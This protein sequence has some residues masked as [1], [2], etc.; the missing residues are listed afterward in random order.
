MNDTVLVTGATGFVGSAVARRLLE[1][2]YRV[3]ALVRQSSA[4]DNLQGLDLE[5]VMGDL[6]DPASLDRALQGC[7]G[8]FH[9]AADYRLWARHP[10]ELYASNVQGTR[11]IML[12]AERAGVRRIVYTSSVATMGLRADGQSAD[13]ETPVTL[14]D[15]IGDYK[16]SKYQAEEMLQ[17]LTAAHDID[18]VTVNP[19]TP[20]GPRD[21]KPTPTGRLIRDAACRRMPAYVDTGLNIVHVDDVAEGHLQAY[22][23]GRRGRRYILG[24]ENLTLRE[25]LERVAAI[26]GHPPPRFALPH[27]AVMPVAWLAE[28]W[29]RVSGREPLVSV[30]GVKLARKK[31]FFTHARAAQEL[32]YHPRPAQ[33]ALVDAVNWF[34]ERGGR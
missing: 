19:S 26:A 29:A 3:R 20:V 16:R 23:Q 11:D 32:N 31:M 17:Q 5:T 12:A 30:T 13:E 14:Q 2:G 6:R 1:N 34:I 27:G 9:V 33:E 18:V 7:D 22:R 28:A 8:L 4:R 10:Q 15:M 25:I 24:G 21:I